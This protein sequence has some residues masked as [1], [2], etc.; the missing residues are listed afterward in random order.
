MYLNLS[1]LNDF[2]LN[3]KHYIMPIVSCYCGSV[4]RAADS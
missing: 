4:G 1:L 3:E 2:T